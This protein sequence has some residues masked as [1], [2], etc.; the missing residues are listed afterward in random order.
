[1]DHAQAD[2]HTAAEALSRACTALW[3][4]T[5]SLMTAFM[6]TSAPVHRLRI[7][8]KI[9]SNFELLREQRD[10]FSPECCAS[11]SNLAKHWTAKADQL[12]RQED[13]PRG[14]LGLFRP[15]LFGVR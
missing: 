15:A 11:F 10:C 6:G 12:A 2:A 4:A 9:A 3:V 5:L 7:A 13:R 1:M 14:G 8:R